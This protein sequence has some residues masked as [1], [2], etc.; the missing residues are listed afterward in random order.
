[1]ISLGNKDLQDKAK[2][3][4]EEQLLKGA[5]IIDAKLNTLALKELSEVDDMKDI[6]GRNKN[7]KI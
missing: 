7:L 2:K 6:V 5:S 3:E 4:Y 1:M